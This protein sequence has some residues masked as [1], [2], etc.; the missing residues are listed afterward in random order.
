MQHAF[1]ILS[2]RLYTASERS[3]LRG[4]GE[5]VTALSLQADWQRTDSVHLAWK[6]CLFYLL[7]H[8]SITRDTGGGEIGGNGVK[9]GA[10][11]LVFDPIVASAA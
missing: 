6:L 2:D 9:L 11:A 1:I 10:P 8:D 7:S 4:E 5:W 3:A